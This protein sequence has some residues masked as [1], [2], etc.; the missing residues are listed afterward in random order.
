LAAA[1]E[2]VLTS[3]GSLKGRLGCL[4]HSRRKHWVYIVGKIER[5]KPMSAKMVN[6]C[7]GEKAIKRVLRRSGSREYFKD[8]EWTDNPEEANSF[9]DAVEVAEIC[10]R[11][12]LTDVELAIRFD[13]GAGEFFCTAIC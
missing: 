11:Y 13:A 1:W 4:P 3:S 10:A 2:Q 9:S 8:G 5:H 12:G 6:E 7:G